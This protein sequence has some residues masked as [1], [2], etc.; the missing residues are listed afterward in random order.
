MSLSSTSHYRAIARTNQRQPYRRF[1]IKPADRLHHV[2]VIGRTGV[3]KSTL[4]EQ[5]F[6]SDVESGAGVALL[7]PHGDLAARAADL[8]PA[9]RRGDLRYL[10]LT[11]SDQP[12]LYNPLRRV[13][14][15]RRALLASG[16][17]E[18]MEKLWPSAWGVRMEHF[19]R[20]AFLTLLDQPAAS[21]PDV[22]RLFRDKAY[23]REALQH[24]TH[25]PIREFW[26]EEFP[27][28]PPFQRAAA[29][30][31]IE[32]KIGAFLSDPRL[33]R[34]VAGGGEELRFRQLMDEGRILVV[35]VAKGTIG[36]DSAGIVG[37]LLLTSL[38]NAALSRSE[39]DTRRSFFIYADECQV[40]ATRSLADMTAELRK[41]GVGVVFAN[42]FLGQFS[43]EVRDSVLSNTGTLIVFRVGPID[44][45]FLAT[46]FEPRFSAH[47]L[48]NQQNH[49]CYIKLMADGALLLPFSATTIRPS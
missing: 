40:F 30:A 14:A 27:K 41:F 4:L 31:P 24:V 16:M 28:L 33:Y 48:L 2:Y 26:T 38:V 45:A 7:D 23:R 32:N 6:R 21:L 46:E 12:F 3:G 8:V 42:Q 5:L 36:A 39:S 13:P 11:D 49:D 20:N 34:L 43:S 10:D 1:G 18:V 25:Q 9:N 35:N 15:E 17:I 37:G 19:L 22:L 29:L 44:A 47:D